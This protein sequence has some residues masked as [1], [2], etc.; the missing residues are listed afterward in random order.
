MTITPPTFNI[1]EGGCNTWVAFTNQYVLEVDFNVA[2]Q[3]VACQNMF[4]T[5]EGVD[6]TLLQMH[7]HSPSEHTVGNGRYA[8]EAHMVHQ[9]L[10]TGGYL[11]IGVF[12]QV[13]SL[14]TPADTN[15]DDKNEYDDGVNRNNAFMNSIWSSNKPFIKNFTTGGANLKVSGSGLM[16]PYRDL[17]PGKKSMYHYYG[18]LTTPPCVVPGGVNWWVY[19]NPVI[20]SANDLYYLRKIVQV[21]GNYLSNRGD[22]ARPVQPLNGRLVSYIPAVPAATT[23]NPTAT[24]STQ[25]G[26]TAAPTVTKTNRDALILGAIAISFVGCTIFV[27][28][29]LLYVIFVERAGQPATGRSS[30]EFAKV[31]GEQA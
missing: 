25:P 6:Y 10:T 7:F 26:P 13:D 24:P 4:V 12:L 15:T 28:L 22:N 3:N 2:A 29:F 8:A 31:P 5:F 27:V 19:D 9:S 18:G 20:I 30:V 23:K 17:T 1:E 16:N 14:N 21:K 11:V